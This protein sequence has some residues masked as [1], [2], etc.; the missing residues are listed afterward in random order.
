M[1]CGRNGNI[2]GLFAVNDVGESELRRLIN[3]E[4]KIYYGEAL[5]K[6][7]LVIGT[8]EDKELTLTCE[9]DNV[10]IVLKALGETVEGDWVTISGH[11][12][13]DYK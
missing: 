5:G 4:T 9:G 10:M 3:E 12:P 2:R 8:L 11:N 1:D 6:H 7:S 13:L